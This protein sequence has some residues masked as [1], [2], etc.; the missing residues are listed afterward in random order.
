MACKVKVNRHGY[1]AFRLYWEGNE[2]W[3]GTE[4]K[5]TPKNRTRAEARA[6]LISDHIENGTF[7]YLKWFP[8][9]NK[10][11]LFGN[12]SGKRAVSISLREAYLMWIADK[13]PPL[14]K[15]SRARKYRSHFNA[16]ILPLHGEL[17]LHQYGMT[18]ISDLRINLVERKKLKIKTAKNVINATLRAFFRD[19][20]ARWV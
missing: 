17:Y 7:D 1:L 5:D 8:N 12:S 6:M 11:H 3:E 15:K 18:Q 19:V 4:W 13:I 14:V 9:G 10:A 16:H 2:S 20:T